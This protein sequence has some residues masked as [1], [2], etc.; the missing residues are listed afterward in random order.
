MKYTTTLCLALITCAA[1]AL[2]AAAAPEPAEAN[3]VVEIPLR[4]KKPHA[5]PFKDVTRDVV[6]TGPKGTKKTV[7]AFWAGGD[8]WKVR[9]ASPVVGAHRYRSECS[10]KD[11]PGLHGIEGRIEIKPYTGN[12][13]LYRHGPIR[14]S[15]NGRYFEHADGTPFFW[16]GDTWWKCLCKRLTWKGFQELTAD[17]KKKGFS[18]IQIVCGP[19]PDEGPFKPSWANEGGLPYKTRDFTVLNPEYWKYA[20]V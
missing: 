11:D 8:Q 16:L 7:P 12:N 20:G 2:S 9:Y 1:P 13:P 18:V 6:F 5:N 19:Y 3:V 10:A 17:R 4:A 15:R 14:V